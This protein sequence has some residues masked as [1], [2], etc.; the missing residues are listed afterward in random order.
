MKVTS[1]S[2]AYNSGDNVDFKLQGQSN[3]LVSLLAFDNR[4]SSDFD[5]ISVNDFLLNGE[6]KEL[7][8]PK[9]IFDSVHISWNSGKA[10]SKSSFEV[11]FL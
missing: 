11:I 3:A 2:E 4:S 1:Q 10:N 8:Y 6:S 5:D 7:P 9:S